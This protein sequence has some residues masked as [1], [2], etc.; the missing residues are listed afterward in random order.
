[1]EG[2][3]EEGPAPGRAVVAQPQ[4]PP[5][6]AAVRAAAGRRRARLQNRCCLRLPAN[7]HRHLPPPPS[8][9][10]VRAPTRAV[11]GRGKSAA[12]ESGGNTRAP[13]ARGRGETPSPPAPSSASRR[14]QGAGAEGCAGRWRWRRRREGAAR[15]PPSCLVRVYGATAETPAC[16][17]VHQVSL[18]Q[19]KEKPQS[20]TKKKS[21]SVRGLFFL[22]ICTTQDDLGATCVEAWTRC[23]TSR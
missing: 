4:P 12:P 2:E 22:T 15:Q 11:R 6:S 23:S 19:G 13:S 16:P 7:P 17:T 20:A 21:Y 10:G 5:C 9:P 1:M 14:F 18:G 3:E 8:P